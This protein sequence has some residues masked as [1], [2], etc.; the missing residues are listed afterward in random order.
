M[1][2][3]FTEIGIAV[4]E[5]ATAIADYRCLLGAELDGSGRLALRN[6]A[7]K[8]VRDE[9]CSAPQIRS[10]GLWLAG[11]TEPLCIDDQRGLCLP[12]HGERSL[13]AADGASSTG[14]T[15]VDHIV[16]MSSD[17]EDCI[18]LFGDR[19]FGMRLALDRQ[20]PEWGGRMLFFRCGKMTL[21]VIHNLDDPPSAD[22][23]WGITYCTGDLA[24]TLD[25]LDRQGVRHSEIRGGRKPGTR[26]ATVKNHHLG[27]PTLLIEPAST[28]R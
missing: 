25:I 9:A 22:F 28:P 8:L 16:L 17:A 23:F 20:V 5:L 27:I 7:I 21:E 10:L 3:G 26:V 6:V 11:D 1:I 13:M 18:R 12:Q 19:G 24:A 4:P 14:I 15:A 2:K